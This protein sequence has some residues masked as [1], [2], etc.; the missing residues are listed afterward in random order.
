MT[1]ADVLINNGATQIT[2]SNITDQR[3]NKTVCGIVHGAVDQVDTTT[4]FNQYQAWFKE[5]TGSVAGEVDAWQAVQ[6]QEF[7]TWFESIKDILEGDVA[8]NLAN[9]ITL[10]D[11]KLSTHEA[12]MIRHNNYGVA[13]GTFTY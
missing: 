3:L 2:Q 8:G 11:Q 9:R 1:L 4:I 12:N 10:L 6:K 7:L 5:I 13:I